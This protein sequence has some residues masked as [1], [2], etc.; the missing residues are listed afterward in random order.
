MDNQVNV[1]VLGQGQ[2]C[3]V[4]KQKQAEIISYGAR[5]C[6]DCLDRRYLRNELLNVCY[7]ITK[8]YVSIEDSSTQFILC[9]RCSKYVQSEILKCYSEIIQLCK[10]LGVKIK[11]TQHY[12]KALQ[13]LWSSYE[14]DFAKAMTVFD[15]IVEQAYVVQKRGLH[16]GCSDDLALKKLCNY[17]EEYYRFFNCNMTCGRVSDI[18]SS[19]KKLHNSLQIIV[20][21]QRSGGTTKC[22]CEIYL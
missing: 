21:K 6:D 7:E 16:Y 9:S 19:I 1:I 15:K 13:S 20:A 2:L 5:Y 11:Y 22:P 10:Q 4:C 3:D 18:C 14:T 17:K 12:K 8:D